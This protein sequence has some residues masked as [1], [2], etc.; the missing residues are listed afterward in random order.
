M[1][2]KGELKGE[3]AVDAKGTQ[4]LIDAAVDL[5]S[6]A[7]ELLG[8]LG[9][10]L[11]LARVG[12]A[13]RITRRAKEIAEQNNLELTAPPLKFLANFYERASLEE[14]QDEEA[15]DRWAELLLS[16][17]SGTAVPPRFISIMAEMDGHQA[18]LLREIFFGKQLV[19]DPRR[20]IRGKRFDAIEHEFLPSSV[21]DVI[22]ELETRAIR[23]HPIDILMD[24]VEFYFNA[25]GVH[26][27]SW[28]LSGA[29]GAEH[30]ET[31]KSRSLDP[32]LGLGLEI[33]VSLGLLGRYQMG[34]VVRLPTERQISLSGEFIFITD[35][36]IQ[37]I[38]AYDSEARKIVN[39]K[40]AA[41][42]NYRPTSRR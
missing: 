34:R 36:G 32:E 24:T 30:S 23:E 25:P 28:L 37:F 31:L 3:V 42:K 38:V 10:T 9:D 33:L 19:H 4:T 7:T 14:P 29:I 41:R 8:L 26:V 18:R 40:R 5:F 22:R 20:S 2:I 12:V 15:H 39:E 13:A 35:L 21:D 1:E 17:S 11:R 16:A 6:P 27:A